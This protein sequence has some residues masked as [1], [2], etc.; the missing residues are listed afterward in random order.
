MTGQRVVSRTKQG[1]EA[2]VA[3]HT[4]HELGRAGAAVAVA[5]PSVVGPEATPDRAPVDP[6]ATPDR[7]PVAAPTPRYTDKIGDLETS[8]KNLNDLV[9]S[10]N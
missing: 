8:S 3:R 4:R 9:Q 1:H 5:I 2:F 7:A 10:I 6:E